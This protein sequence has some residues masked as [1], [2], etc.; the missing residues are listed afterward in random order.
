[1][2][3]HIVRNLMYISRANQ[4]VIWFT[5]TPDSSG[6]NSNTL[7]DIQEVIQSVRQHALTTWGYNKP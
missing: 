7:V 1:M 2:S 4:T 6:V 3:H 5:L